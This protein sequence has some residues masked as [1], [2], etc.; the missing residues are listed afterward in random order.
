MRGFYGGYAFI[1]SRPFPCTTL[2]FRWDCPHLLAP[3]NPQSSKVVEN[4]LPSE[5][6]AEIISVTDS[7]CNSPDAKM[8]LRCC[9]MLSVVQSNRTDMAFLVAVGL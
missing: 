6:V 4:Y 5:A 3:H 9:P 7:F 1:D 2:P 8:F